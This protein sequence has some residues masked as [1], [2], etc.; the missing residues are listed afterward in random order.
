MTLTPQT[1]SRRERVFS[2][3]WDAFAQTRK[4]MRLPVE[5]A[6]DKTGD[7][8]SATAHPASPAWTEPAVDAME[9][10]PD[11]EGGVSAALAVERPG[12]GRRL[13]ATVAASATISAQLKPSVADGCFNA[14]SYAAFLAL[15]LLLFAQFAVG[16]HALMPWL[17]PQE[18][19][20][21][22]SYELMVAS[23]QWLMA[24]AALPPAWFWMLRLL[25]ML[26]YV[27]GPLVY[28]AGAALSGVLTLLATWFLALSAGYTRRTA[29]AAG[30][31][32][33]SCLAFPPLAH[34]VGPELFSAGLLTM[35][36][37]CLLRGWNK[38][39]SFLWLPLGSAFVALAGLAGG[40]FGLMLPVSGTLLFV[41]WKGAFA[42]LNK[43][44]GAIGFAVLLALPLAW[45]AAAMLFGPGEAQVQAL[46]LQLIKPLLPPY[47]PP[48]DPVW[49]YAAVLPLALAPWILAPFFVSWGSALARPFTLLA[50]TRN[51]TSGSAW[52]WIHLV[53]GL[54]LLSAMSA[55]FC[56]NMLPLMPLLA[57]VLG[58]AIVNLPKANSRAFFLVPVCLFGLAA[59]ALGLASLLQIMPQLQGFV[60]LPYPKGFTAI[61]G[62][63]VLAGICLLSA[64]VLWKGIDRRFPG[65]CLLL[66]AIAVTALSLTALKLTSPGLQDII[67]GNAAI[68]QSVPAA[69]A[70]KP[71]AVQ[72]PATPAATPEAEAPL[73]VP[74]DPAVPQSEEKS[75]ISTQP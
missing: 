40:V 25:N 43:A 61:K 28:V 68:Q 24:P 1:D 11:A 16:F 5:A 45:L 32:L 59:L 37:A 42:R 73:P 67:L 30:L 19:Q 49:L 51:A 75:V 38:D 60:P 3:A 21:A 12:T 31:V 15:P 72:T 36:L 33:L 69:P 4:A 71:S 70:P 13:S 29:F 74:P 47:W 63:P 62:L 58:K 54:L 53:A 7:A 9:Q 66:C 6:V 55:K 17:L 46:C 50:S 18:A 14:L 44:D 8:A 41:V 27:D 10:A 2:N 20:F 56:L 48:K 22:Q 52:I 34:L 64:F 39:V 23:G 26:P 57:I 65:P 35:G